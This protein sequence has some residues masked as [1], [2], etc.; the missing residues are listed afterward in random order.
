MVVNWSFGKQTL[1][2][3]M[4]FYLILKDVRSSHRRLAP[5]ADLIKRKIRIDPSKAEMDGW[6]TV[7]W[8]LGSCNAHFESTCMLLQEFWSPLEGFFVLRTPAM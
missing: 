2:S 7:E 3:I 5:S 8:S 6:I 4:T 1:T